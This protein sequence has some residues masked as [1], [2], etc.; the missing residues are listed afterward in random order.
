MQGGPRKARRGWVAL[1]AIVAAALMGSGS[2]V[3]CIQVGV[4]QD[5][6]ATSLPKLQRAVGPGMNVI[7]TYVTI[8]RPVDPVVVRTARARK[9][10]LMVT[11]MI[12]NGRGGPSQP[13]YSTARVASG[14]YDRQ[15]RTLARQLR[16]MRL[17]VILRPMPEPNTEWYPWSGTLNG[18]TAASYVNAWN[19]VRRVVKRNAGTRV[20]LLWSP[21]FRSV[22]DIDDNAIDQYFPGAAN[23]DLVGVSGYNFGAT[24]ELEWLTPLELFQDPY[25]EIRNLTTKPFWLAEVGTTARGGNKADWLR[26]L[27][28]LEKSLPG[29]RGMVLYDVREPAGDFR[30]SV[31]KKTQ[32]STRAILATRCGAKKKR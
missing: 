1:I 30:I 29:L 18:N 21:Y 9:A 27:A 12:D 5:A 22:P 20:K 11:L 10:T 32:A 28:K 13:S 8:G 25:I 6:P 31:T 7:S 26:Q 19:R 16:A 3:A 2:A 14:R 15:V 17:N 23:V 4:Y 24:G